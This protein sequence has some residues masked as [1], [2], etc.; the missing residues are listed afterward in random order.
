[1]SQKPHFNAAYP[2]KWQNSVLAYYVLKFLQPIADIRITP[3]YNK[4]FPIMNPRSLVIG[5][6]AGLL[7]VIPSLTYAQEYKIGVLAN[8]GPLQ[9]FKEWKATAD[10][11][12]TATGK[13]FSIVPLE[14]DQL[15]QWTDEKKIDFVLT[16]SAMYAELSK[17]YGVQAIA[18]QVNQYKDQPLDKFGS[19]VLVR[20][21]SPVEN[22][23]GLKGK[24]FGCASH[25]AFGGW[26]MTVRLLQENGINPDSG[27]ASV[28]ELKTH[29]NVIYAVL[30]G[31]VDAGS[32]RTGTLE[33][34]VQEGKVNLSDFKVIHR[35][36]DDFPLL[37]STQLYPEY[38]M[39]VCRHVPAEVR[40][41]VSKALISI[42]PSEPSLASAKIA[43]WKEPLEYRPVMECLVQIKYGAF[44]DQESAAAGSTEQAQTPKR[45]SLP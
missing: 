21:D 10:Y 32:V 8:R 18:T 28:K 24:N 26:L 36:S 31:A 29:D 14:Y 15:P 2:L 23:S 3:A 6:L 7:W 42:P 35:I 22:L 39:A 44:K 13:S 16:N 33:K 37:H 11:L 9:A 1:L 12:S 27:F 4:E 45:R 38:P 40:K 34:M 17:V 25:S 5:L 19:L 43:G 41:Q 30:N 20:Q